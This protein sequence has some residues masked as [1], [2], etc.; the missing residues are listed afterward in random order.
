LTEQIHQPDL[1]IGSADFVK[2]TENTRSSRPAQ[3]NTSGFWSQ[4]VV[5]T[6]P[7]RNDVT[8]MVVHK[9]KTFRSPLC[10]HLFVVGNPA[11]VRPVMH[12]EATRTFFHRHVNAHGHHL[13]GYNLADVHLGVY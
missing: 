4:A 12:A 6:S 1:A 7:R 10:S 13:V 3:A 11:D 5:A 8:P 2:S 9:C